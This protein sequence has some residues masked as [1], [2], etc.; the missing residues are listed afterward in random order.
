MRTT[1]DT[2]WQCPSR[3]SFCRCIRGSLSGFPPTSIT[4]H[5]D[6]CS[7]KCN[8]V[9]CS[10]TIRKIRF[11][12]H[13]AQAWQGVIEGSTQKCQTSRY[14]FH[15]LRSHPVNESILRNQQVSPLLVPPLSHRDNAFL[16]K[17]SVWNH[18]ESFVLRR[19]EN[20]C[21][22]MV[23]ADFFSLFDNVHR[24]EWLSPHNSRVSMTDAPWPF[25]YWVSPKVSDVLF[26]TT[27]W[28]LPCF[29]CCHPPP[30]VI[31]VP[32]V[33]RTT[34]CCILPLSLSSSLLVRLT[35][36]ALARVHPLPP[37]TSMVLSCLQHTRARILHLHSSLQQP[38]PAPANSMLVT[39]HE[40]SRI[41]D[42]DYLL[43]PLF[44]EIAV[45][46]L[47]QLVIH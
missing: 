10:N 40:R 4:E 34:G 8:T 9:P 29:F 36:A 18:N 12:Y 17:I 11:F 6:L 31:P 35:D 37:V 39:T 1:C 3:C 33:P 30:E 14:R 22:H 13:L 43:F 7:R 24:L 44:P 46:L 23:L 38:V 15:H 28:P 2:R 16:A 20:I 47:F 19:R 42:S 27:S 41:P 21:A 5:R 26:F 25:K 32:H 45:R